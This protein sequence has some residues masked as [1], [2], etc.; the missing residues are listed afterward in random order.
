MNETPMDFENRILKSYA[1]H[2][3]S[4]FF[5]S[6]IERESSDM[7]GPRRFNE[8]VVWTFDWSARKNGNLIHTAD[9][10]RGSIR[11]HL[12]IVES[13]IKT[14]AAPDET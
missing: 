6:T 8:T 3:N 13:Y 2:G 1:W 5:V 4:C 7:E 11:E 14:G 12:R 9:D 10:S